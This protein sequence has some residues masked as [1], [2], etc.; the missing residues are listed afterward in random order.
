MNLGLYNNKHVTKHV[1]LKSKN[2]V[3]VTEK[4]KSKKR[5]ANQVNLGVKS[6]VLRTNNRFKEPEDNDINY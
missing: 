6:K 1:N 2:I 4:T 5:K 3:M